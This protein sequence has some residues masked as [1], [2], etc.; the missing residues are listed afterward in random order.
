MAIP[1][2]EGAPSPL[3][4]RLDRLAADAA[5]QLVDHPYFRGLRDGTLP[6]SVLCQYIL[7]DCCHLLPAYGRALARCAAHAPAD[8]HA[9]LLTGMA[10]ASL[11]DSA[12]RVS[13]FRRWCAESG[14]PIPTDAPPP[15][16]PTTAAYGHYLLSATG[17]SAFAAGVGA[18]LPSAWLF[19]LVNDDLLA[20]HDPGSRY[21]GLITANHP[22]AGFAAVL[23]D[24]LRLA[25]QAAGR[26][27]ADEA[28]LLRN[29]EHAI[30]YE[31][32]FTAA[33]WRLES[34]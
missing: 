9:E 10:A 14:V 7:Q 20:R 28:D 27:Q 31:H 25:E 16:A 26:G 15:V 34:R 3:R 33:S 12:N 17:G 2:P 18:L 1:T 22:G 8:R 13:R 24:F 21:A 29:C 32:A 5:A 30:R 6:E 19:L 4:T 11:S 23:E